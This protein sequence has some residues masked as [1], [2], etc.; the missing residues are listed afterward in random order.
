MRNSEISV[1]RSTVFVVD[2]DPAILRSMRWL[3][4]SVGLPVRTFPSAKEFLDEYNPDMPGCLVLD[5]R[6]PGISGL[7]L[8]E[9]LRERGCEIPIIIV[10][11]FADVPMA[12]RAMKNGAAHFLQKPCSEQILLDQ[13]QQA[14]L[15]DVDNRKQ[16]THRLRTQQRMASL[17]RRE[18]EVLEFVVV[19]LSSREI[20]DRLGIS[21]K[22]IETHRAKILK[23]MHAKNA[24]HLIH[25][26]LEAKPKPGKSISPEF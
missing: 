26:Y 15:R 23:K 11:G 10:T 20:A 5:V 1:Q 17:S 3:I 18:R 6:M 21:S 2:D 16:I 25:I 13:I 14:V 24:P 9:V 4:E 8:Q 22:T 19:G 7:E 12:V